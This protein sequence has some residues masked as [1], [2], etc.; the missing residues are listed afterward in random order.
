MRDSPIMVSLVPF[1]GHPFALAA[2]TL[3]EIGVQRIEPALIAGYT[4][5]FDEAIFTTKLARSWRSV[6]AAAGLSCAAFS[7]HVDIGAPGGAAQVSRRLRFAAELGAKRLVTNAAAAEYR[8]EFFCAM[9]RLILEAQRYGVIIAL[10]NPGNGRPNLIDSAQS[11]AKLVARFDSPW[12]SLNYDPGNLLTHQPGLRPE[13][14]V[15][16]LDSQ[17][18]GSLHLKNAALATQALGASLAKTAKGAGAA[19]TAA[20]AK[21]AARTDGPGGYWSFVPLSAGVIDYRKILA[22]TD[23]MVPRP[24]YCIELPLRLSRECKGTPHRA[25]KP[26]KI[27]RI[28]EV[29]IESLEW[30]GAL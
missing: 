17:V 26:V 6:A 9:E 30:L 14:D 3:T 23:K 19:S 15:L 22:H 24:E 4:D 11:A 20:L 18:L 12:V 1:D 2:E 5:P 27:Q 10:E 21:G 16:S 28:R 8:E 29:L 7:A 13:E 25:T